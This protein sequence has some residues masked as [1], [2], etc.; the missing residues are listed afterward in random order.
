MTPKQVLAVLAARWP[1]AVAVLL[2]SIAASAVVS[3]TM[4]KR[5][6]ASAMVMLDARTPDQVAGGGR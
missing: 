1:W 4:L 3:T 5:Y 2:I 6:T